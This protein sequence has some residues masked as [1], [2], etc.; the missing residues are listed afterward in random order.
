MYSDFPVKILVNLLFLI[1]DVTKYWLTNIKIHPIV[2]SCFSIDVKLLK[3][4]FEDN[5]NQ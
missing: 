4:C 5:Y 2:N 1:L 3:H